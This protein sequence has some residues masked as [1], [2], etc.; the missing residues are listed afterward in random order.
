[1][2]LLLDSGAVGAMAVRA[3]T[4][5]VQANAVLSCSVSGRPI[6]LGGDGRHKATDLKYFGVN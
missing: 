1:M 2:W 6:P 5:V 4:M 3:T